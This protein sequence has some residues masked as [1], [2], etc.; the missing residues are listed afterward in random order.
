MSE[1]SWTPGPWSIRHSHDRSGD[2]GITHPGGKNVLAECFAD[3]R[4][5]RERSPE[6]LA[7]AHLIASAPDLYE[8]LLIAHGYVEEAMRNDDTGALHKIDAALAK[9]RGE[10]EGQE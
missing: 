4:H 9:A 7:N 2:I 10:K 6:A 5:D 1:T 8:A 3:I